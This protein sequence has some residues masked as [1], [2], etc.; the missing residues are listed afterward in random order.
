MA[1][2]ELKGKLAL[3]TGGAR[4]I[5]RATAAELLRAG[6]RVA[7]CDIDLQ[8]AERTANE[9]SPRGDVSAYH[10]DVTDQAEF[11]RA[12]AQI[13]AE[14][15][16]IDILINNAGIMSLGAFL[17]HEEANDRKQFEI[18]VFGVMHGMRAVLPRMRTRGAGHIVNVASL[19]GRVG[20]P[21]AAGYTAS[22]FAVIGM[23]ESVR[24]ELK[25][26]GIG[27]TYVMP[28]LVNTDLTAGTKALFWP[29]IVEPE[30]VAKALVDG[31]R[32]KKLEVYVP[33]IGRLTAMLPA[34]LPRV[35]VDW[36]GAKMG[37]TQL[38]R[39]VDLEKRAAYLARTTG[40]IDEPRAD[41]DG[42][43]VE[44]AAKSK[45]RSLVN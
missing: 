31:V 37:L 11:N 13:E 43:P 5:G 42:E 1:N 2:T 4:G 36:V 6:A 32:R 19:A 26:S 41:K 24:N 9:L 20:I 34:V 28:Y 29:P 22:K 10:L 21:N 38:F 40:R 45:P 33:R 16:P 7:I 18:N 27:F 14:K 39:R 30:D 23:T 15:G 25:G 44:K 8:I 12:V 35:L 3:I 17:E